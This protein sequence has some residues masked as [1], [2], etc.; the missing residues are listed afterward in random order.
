M[1]QR[2]PFVLQTALNDYNVSYEL[3]AYTFA[4]NRMP[5]MY[6]ELHRSVQDECAAA[7]IE[8]L[9]PLYAA[10]R[11]GS[12]STIPRAQQHA[13]LEVL[14]TRSTRALG[15][16]DLIGDAGRLEFHRP[17]FQ[18]PASFSRPPP[19]SPALPHLLMSFRG[20][21]RNPSGRT[22]PI[23]YP[24]AATRPDSSPGTPP[25]SAV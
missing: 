13:T 8:I 5:R 14:S 18:S 4:P 2:R 3:N 11:D 20:R 22:G 23:A 25:A 7:G 17:K 12:T 6:S 1:R 10:T 16:A 15:E 9:S 21:T 19:P 24:S